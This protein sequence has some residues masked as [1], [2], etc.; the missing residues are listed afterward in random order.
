MKIIKS[1]SIFF[2]ILS[3]LNYSQNT[4]KV[5][6]PER[7]VYNYSSN[8]ILES[9]KIDI[10]KS[11]NNENDFSIIKNK[12]YIGPLLWFNF[13]TNNKLTDLQFK[14]VELNVDKL[15]ILGQFSDNIDNSK[16]VW[17]EFKNLIL[18]KKFK[19]RKANKLELEYYWTLISWDIEEPLFVIETDENR[20]FILDFNKNSNELLWIDEFSPNYN[21]S[22]FLKFIKIDNNNVFFLDKILIKETK[23]K[24]IKLLNK[25][26]ELKENI[27]IDEM[28]RIIDRTNILFKEVVEDCKKSGKI[29]VEFELLKENNKINV[30]VTEE[31]DNE[32]KSNFESKLLKEDFS[33]S[34]KDS[35]KFIMVYLVNSI[36]KF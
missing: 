23:L 17:N 25:D 8:E 31:L 35:I 3:N 10:L 20:N 14:K 26:K 7:V 21:S 28:K 11:I 16:K 4:E 32:L 27:S 12:L 36:D 6:K 29:I 34:K 2:V 24:T 13:K 1:I 9:V 15:K 33:N 30:I 5:D 18:N 22:E 19:I